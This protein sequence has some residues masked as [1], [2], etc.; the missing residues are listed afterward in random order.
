MWCFVVVQFCALPVG[1]HWYAV[2]ITFLQI[3]NCCAKNRISVQWCSKYLLRFNIWHKILCLLLLIF[4]GLMNAL[5]MGPFLHKNYQINKKKS[6][7]TTVFSYIHSFTLF[8]ESILYS[9]YSTNVYMKIL[10]LIYAH[11]KTTGYP[12]Y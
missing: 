8:L 7:M 3:E 2:C 11:L 4:M 9:L 6:D 5:K 1:A 10:K 12:F